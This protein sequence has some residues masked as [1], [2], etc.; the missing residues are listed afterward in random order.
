MSSSAPVPVAQPR[1]RSMAGAVVLILLGIVL[2]L[3]TTG[4]LHGYKLWHLYGKF[5]PALIILWGVIKLVEH[6]QAQRVGARSSGI[7]AGGVFLLIFLIV[8]GLAATSTSNINWRGLHDEIGWD[9]GD[10]DN[11]FGESFSYTDQ[12]EEAF[13]AGGSLR[14]VSDRGA[15]NIQVSDDNK[16]KV[17]IEKKVH[18]DNQQAADKY[19][20]G[21]KPTI[22]VSDKVVNLN[23]NTQAAGD[24]GVATDMTITI[25]RRAPVTVSTRRGDVTINGRAGDINVSNQHGDVN[26]DDIQGNANLSV[27]HSSV[28]A[29]NISGDLSVEGRV[30][31]ITISDIKGAAHL[32][33]EFMESV[34]LSNVAKGVTFKSSRTD[35]EFSKL[36]GN[37]D[38]DSGDLR[39][40]S[41]SGPSR[42]ITKS[43]D[44]VL[45]QVSG[46]LRLEDTNGSVEVHVSKMGNLQIANRSGDVQIA[47][48]PGAA[49][50]ADA[51]A[52]N[53]E[54]Q[55]D[56]SELKIDNQHDQAV[57]TGAVGNG[58]A[59]LKVNN[60]HGT[61]EIRKATEDAAVP[62]PPAPAKAPRIP[63][64]KGAPEE[65]EN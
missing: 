7:G 55:S 6:Q 32:N 19:N 15:V 45:D 34:R 46:D 12:M 37:L 28:K 33:G 14:V 47:L 48:P 58:T 9:E 44:I 18:A 36:D 50:R 25:P 61:I 49:F 10:L 35:L 63:A 60:E 8:T 38:L 29:S 4:V 11:L 26:L 2:L 39:A 56:W 22:T 52:R 65:S 27:Q 59:N 53:G 54:I 13:P 51:R 20:E 24:H 41:L 3:S 42:L 43:K 57:A 1:R 5:W 62:A 30:D 21:T 23:A 16:I 40:S 31:D 17:S 64:P